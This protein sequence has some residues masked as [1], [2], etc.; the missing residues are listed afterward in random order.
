MFPIDK[1]PRLARLTTGKRLTRTSF[2]LLSS[3]ADV[4][5][6]FVVCLSNPAYAGNDHTTLMFPKVS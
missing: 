1:F 4:A 3:D 5:R 6:L 2:D